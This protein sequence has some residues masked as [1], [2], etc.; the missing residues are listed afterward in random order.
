MCIV[1]ATVP[2]VFSTINLDQLKS[3]WGLPGDEVRTRLVHYAMLFAESSILSLEGCGLRVLSGQQW[4]YNSK[5]L[6]E[7]TSSRVR[8]RFGF[9]QFYTYV[10][11]KPSGEVTPDLTVIE[12]FDSQDEAHQA[13]LALLNDAA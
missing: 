11:P 10:G 2:E 6:L 3:I 9:Q 13:Y 7:V 8:E 1:S 4:M 5:C 12:G